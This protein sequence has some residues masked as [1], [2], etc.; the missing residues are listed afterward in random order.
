MSSPEIDSSDV[1]ELSSIYLK[2]FQDYTTKCENKLRRFFSTLNE[3]VNV[4]KYPSAI[5]CCRANQ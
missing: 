3:E 2:W 1:D 5:P 4:R